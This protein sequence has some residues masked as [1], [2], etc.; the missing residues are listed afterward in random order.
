M[1][2][3]AQQVKEVMTAKCHPDDQ[4][5]IKCKLGN[6]D[7]TRAH[8]HLSAWN[9]SDRIFNLD[10]C[11]LDYPADHIISRRVERARKSVVHI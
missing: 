3:L 6:S 11:W 1:Q 2:P 9:L 8:G 4:N 5:Q 7:G 10:A